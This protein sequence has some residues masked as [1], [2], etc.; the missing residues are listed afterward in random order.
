MNDTPG[1]SMHGLA[2]TPTSLVPIDPTLEGSGYATTHP[3]SWWM[4]LTQAH[5]PQFKISHY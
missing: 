5:I 2:S 1:L 3:W 4:E